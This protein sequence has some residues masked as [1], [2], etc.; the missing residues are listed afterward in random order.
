MR[1]PEVSRVAV[2]AEL[3]LDAHHLE[4][5]ADRQLLIGHGHALVRVRVT[6]KA[7]STGLPLQRER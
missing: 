4:L 3:R 7:L 1:V 5:D 2:G 6:S